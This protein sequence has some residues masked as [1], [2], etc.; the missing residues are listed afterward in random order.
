[1]DNLSGKSHLNGTRQTGDAVVRVQTPEEMELERKRAELDS[2]ESELSHRELDLE[3]L[4]AEL[5]SFERQYLRTVGI[6][7]AELDNLEAEIAELLAKKEPPDADAHKRASQARQRAKESADSAREATESRGVGEFKPSESLR[8]LF[9]EAAKRIHPDLADDEDESK[10]RNKIMA[11]A[12]DAYRNGDEEQ[13]QAILQQW[14]HSPDSVR[15]EGVG[16]DLVRLIRKIH[17]AHERLKAI[18]TEMAALKSSE[19]FVLRQH[20]WDALDQGRDLLREMANGLEQDI[21][22]AR[23]RLDRTKATAKHSQ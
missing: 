13:L 10:R 16:A 8:R 18:D 1:M 4:R 11:D 17:L 2:L 22:A 3:T 14:E 20:V 6:R 21:A 19:L 7:L 5:Q 15:G 23:R 12:N 9:R